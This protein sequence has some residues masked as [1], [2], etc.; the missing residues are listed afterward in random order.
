MVIEKLFLVIWV[1]INKDVDIFWHKMHKKCRMSSW[2]NFLGCINVY[3]LTRSYHLTWV[4]FI[5]CPADTTR[6]RQD[7]RFSYLNMV[8]MSAVFVLLLF[9][10]GGDCIGRVEISPLS[11]GLGVGVPTLWWISFI[12]LRLSFRRFRLALWRKGGFTG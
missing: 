1:F 12:I 6:Q 11:C 9:Y 8:M 5:K 10:Q 3:L 4:F 2:Y 7:A